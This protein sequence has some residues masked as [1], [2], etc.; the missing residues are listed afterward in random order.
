MAN[1]NGST[2]NIPSL[3][4][5]T[6]SHINPA[7]LITGPELEAFALSNGYGQ[8]LTGRGWCAVFTQATNI[9]LPPWQVGT[10]TSNAQITA[11]QFLRRLLTL[12]TFEGQVAGGVGS[13]G[14]NN[15]GPGNVF[16]TMNPQPVGTAVTGILPAP[17][18]SPNTIS[19]TT[20]T[21]TGNLSG[22]WVG[23][24]CLAAIVW[25]KR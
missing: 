3:E 4:V 22:F 19:F 11:A 18:A 16:P 1:G 23:V 10:F 24:L 7:A 21:I 20:P 12:Q 25:W 17:G 6:G 9:Q 8:Y 14:T 2:T 13:N 5:A 15:P